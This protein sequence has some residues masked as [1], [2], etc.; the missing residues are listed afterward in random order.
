MVSISSGPSVINYD[1]FTSAWCMLTLLYLIPA[2]VTDSIAFHWAL[3]VA[4]DAINVLF[5]FCAAVA[6]PA[7]LGVN[8]C[9]DGVSLSQSVYLASNTD[10]LQVYLYEN[11]VTAN[12]FQR[13]REAQASTAFLWFAWASFVVS[14]ALSVMQGR[15]GSTRVSGP[16][17]G[18]AMS[19]V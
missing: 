12:S 19:Q 11:I 7:Y 16:R 15:G 2:T 5:L 9:N 4:L 14:L 10:D 6:T 18:P 8:S 1:V 3:P 13:C 17:R